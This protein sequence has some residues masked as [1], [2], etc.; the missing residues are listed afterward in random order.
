MDKYDSAFK[1]IENPDK[2]SAKEI[3]EILSDPD[4]REIYDT[5]CLTKSAL[6]GRRMATDTD[7]NTA[8]DVF[9][10][11]QLR[12]RFGLIWNG[13]RAASIYTFAL[14]SLAA[15]AIGVAV[16]VSVY[17]PQS[18][19][20]EPETQSP[21]DTTTQTVGIVVLNDSLDG[22]GNETLIPTKPII[23]EDESLESILNQMSSIY[24]VQV[25]Y[26]SSETARLHLYYKYEPSLSLKEVIDQL[27]TFEQINIQI[28]DKKLIVK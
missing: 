3:N 17:I 26:H 1:L 11:K 25:E 12:R 18:Q 16:T 5:L 4:V 6:N 9:K 28:D 14:S 8:W 27:N 7:V 19:S 13:N 20:I 10:R 22:H 15:V 23:F 21:I 2:Y 24:A